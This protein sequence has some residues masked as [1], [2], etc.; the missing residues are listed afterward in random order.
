MEQELRSLLKAVDLRYTIISSFPSFRGTLRYRTSRF[1]RICTSKSSESRSVTND[2][3]KE[4]AY[5]VGAIIILS[6]SAFNIALISS[7]RCPTSRAPRTW[8]SRPSCTS[9]W[10]LPGTLSECTPWAGSSGLRTPTPTVTSQSLS[11]SPS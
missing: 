6:N 5:W 7:C 1:I 8:P 11:V 2:E 3:R 4:C 10:P 9:R